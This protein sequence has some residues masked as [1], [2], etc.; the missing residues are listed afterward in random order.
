MESCS[1]IWVLQSIIESRFVVN[2][3][4]FKLITWSK[5]RFRNHVSRH[6]LQSIIFV[7]VVFYSKW[8]H[9][10]SSRFNSKWNWTNGPALMSPHPVYFVRF[11]RVRVWFKNH[12]AY[13]CASHDFQDFESQEPDEMCHIRGFLVFI[14]VQM[15]AFF[16]W[17]EGTNPKSHPQKYFFFCRSKPLN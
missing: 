14:R 13:V 1:K 3:R 17:G 15:W 8:N 6:F 5:N 16:M 2:N 10:S 4:L 12:S 11:T 9:V 7:T